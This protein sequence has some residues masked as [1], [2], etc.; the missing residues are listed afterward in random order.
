MKKSIISAILSVTLVAFLISCQ[1]SLV[2]PLDKTSSAAAA[3]AAQ[4]AATTTDPLANLPKDLG[5]KHTPIAYLSTT[6][7]YGYYLYTP[8]AYTATGAKY[9]LLIFLHGSGET[10]N[11]ATNIKNLDKVLVNGPP[12]LIKAGQ[13]NPKY[14]MVV[15]SVQ[16]HE[17]WWD[18]EKV[19]KFTEYMMVHYQVD[20]TRIYMTG[21]SMGGYGTWDQVT[22]FGRASHI[23]AA[24]PISGSGT[25]S[26]YRV[27]N[28]SHLPV[29]AFHGEA[30]KT[31]VP[32]FDIAVRKAI[33]LLNP[34]VKEKLSMYIG[35]GHDAW[36]KTYNGTGIGKADPAYDPFNMDIYSWMLQYKK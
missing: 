19:K 6:A 35:T 17:G 31:V 29:W 7:P 4:A 15:V 10:G 12:K 24:V 1:D 11:S 2:Q 14:P 32:D 3:V 18:V 20:T 8:S 36:T 22:K 16:C 25:A 28:A 13:W 26:A 5:G 27:K 30:D 9:P 23:T 34:V 21:L 33:N